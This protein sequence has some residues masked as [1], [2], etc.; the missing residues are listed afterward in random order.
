MAEQPQVEYALIFML[1]WEFTKKIIRY[2]NAYFFTVYNMTVELTY[3]VKSNA[4][5][6][7]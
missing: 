4:A 5:E 1:L 7:L 3:I 6:L 2:W